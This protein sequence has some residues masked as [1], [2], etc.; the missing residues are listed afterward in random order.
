MPTADFDPNDFT[1]KGMSDADKALLVKFY[2]D[3]REDIHESRKEGRPVYRDMEI[4]DIRSPGNR[5]EARIRVATP[6]DKAR[7]PEHYRMFK[8][9][10]ESGELEKQTG[11]PLEEYPA[12]SRSQVEEL[13]FFH[14]HTVENLAGMTDATA[15]DMRHGVRMKEEAIKWLEVA[16][17][18]AAAKKLQ[19]DNEAKDKRISDLEAKLEALLSGEIVA[20]T[21]S[22]KKKVTEPETE[23]ED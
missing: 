10:I 12:I 4:I 7:F 14:V 6:R 8:A 2:L 21:K 23:E 13:K 22:R 5:S 16:G 1:Q 11:T 17:N 9:R 15:L 19:E 3:S 18:S 20:K